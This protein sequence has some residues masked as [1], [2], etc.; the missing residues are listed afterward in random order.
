[1]PAMG[2]FFIHLATVSF[3]WCGEGK[4]KG[5]GLD[6]VVVTVLMFISIIKLWQHTSR[7]WLRFDRG[8]E[9]HRLDSM[10]MDEE[11]NTL[12]LR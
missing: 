5:W 4:G 1:M 10:I 6:G 2:V 3:V 11:G 9:E 8:A 7:I 12:F